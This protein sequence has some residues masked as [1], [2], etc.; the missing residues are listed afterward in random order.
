M[1]YIPL[2]QQQQKFIGG[3]A[4]TGTTS[5]YTP[6]A[7][8]QKTFLSTNV[9]PVSQPKQISK[10]VAKPTNTSGDIFQSVSKFTTDIIYNITP[11]QKVISPLAQS[12]PIQPIK[13]VPKQIA[14]LKVDFMPS[15][16]NL[17][18]PV[19]QPSAQLKPLDKGITLE[20]VAKFILA[21]AAD[22]YKQ[23]G[24]LL[25]YKMSDKT[26]LSA[27]EAFKM[28]RRLVDRAKTEKD[29]AQKKRLLDLSRQIDSDVGKNQR[30]FIDFV[31][32][33]AGPP[34]TPAQA[35]IKTAAGVGQII[36]PF[37]KLWKT[38]FF[39]GGL[40]GGLDSISRANTTQEA[41]ENLPQGVAIGAVAA[42]GFKGLGVV[43]KKILSNLKAGE[44]TPQE[45]IGAV[46]KSGQEKTPEGK[47]LVKTA[48]EAQKQG[49]NIMIE[50]PK[51]KQIEA[52][53]K[54]AIVEGEGFTMTEKANKQKVDIGKARNEYQKALDSY[55]QNPTPA[56][57]AKVQELRKRVSELRQKPIEPVVSDKVK[58]TEPI[59]KTEAKITPEAK[60]VE[61]APTQATGGE[62]PPDLQPLAREAR[63]IAA[64]GG[65]VE[66]FVRGQGKP[67]YHGTNAD[68]EVFDKS[69]IG[70]ATDEGL[71]GRG[72]Y[73]GNTESFAR[74]A[75]KG[76]LA[77]IV[78]EVY[79]ISTK[80]FDISKIKNRKEMAD[81]LNMSE[82]ALIE[83][84]NGGLIRPVRGQ[85]EQFTS[86]IKDLG[87]DGVVIKR[88]GDAIETVIFEPD[89]IK[90]KSQLEKIYTQATGG[91]KPKVEVKPTIVSVP[92][93]Q[94]PV[95][96]K[97]GIEKISRLEARVTESLDKTPQEIKDQLG[98]TFTTMNKKE[99]IAKAVDYV[100]KNPEDAMRVLRGEIEAPKDILKN[101]IY[102]AMEN[103][104]RGDVTLAR[105]LA[106]L[107]STRAGQE[108]SIL[109]EID[110][111]SPVK[112]MRDI[113]KVREEAFTKRYSG[114]TSQE[115]SD[116]IVKDIQ[117]K[118]K[119]PDK[120]DWNNFVKS[121]EC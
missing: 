50:A 78:M 83:D 47:A 21:G 81:L 66:E 110:P 11:K 44:N 74:V 94:L 48:L 26:Q 25:G 104:A 35:A 36:A 72:F 20:D 79:P 29:L 64:R 100:I 108:L 49:Q 102:V 17:S 118:V 58:P 42:V 77:K 68:F 111:N 112:I 52:P 91:V 30:E 99:N 88:G 107:A 7:E 76:R 69:K 32:Q 113:I 5:G 63:K 4:S 73:F 3:K 93:E 57:L 62:I 116:K 13:P 90:T 97:E 84:T 106:S 22:S 43:G 114:K 2:A 10:P 95:A 101:S 85:V 87:Y 33:E 24:V 12:R 61:K 60:I 89:K 46:I 18:A 54:R 70:T 6:L 41:I 82:D 27:E 9:K 109:T 23:A 51:A 8:A 92:R 121:L 71:F 56:K 53:K 40:S 15:K 98:S 14:G 1:V 120:Y 96:S 28:S 115:V 37:G 38:T 39:L 119:K 55:N 65:T 105:K 59:V 45:V 75:P 80:L 117:S 67:L 31:K 16:V 86:H 103:M 19:S 34:L